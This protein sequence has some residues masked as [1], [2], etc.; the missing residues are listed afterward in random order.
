MR[1]CILMY[2]SH[3]QVE[4]ARWLSTFS[5]IQCAS[6]WSLGKLGILLLILTKLFSFG[7]AKLQ[8]VKFSHTHTHMHARTHACTHTHT[9]IGNGKASTSQPPWAIQYK[10]KTDECMLTM[11][12]TP[13]LDQGLSDYCQTEHLPTRRFLSAAKASSCSM[14]GSTRANSSSYFCLH[15]RQTTDTW[16]KTAMARV[17]WW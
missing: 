12:D 3:L 16:L 8:L 17:R 9:C 6:E 4:H 7:S 14:K 5:S 15:L 2:A 1:L 13:N 10:Q 11:K